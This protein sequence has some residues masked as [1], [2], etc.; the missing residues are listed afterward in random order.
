M[1]S[2]LCKPAIHILRRI[3]SISGWF[4]P[5]VAKAEDAPDPRRPR[6]KLQYFT[7]SPWQRRGWGILGF[8]SG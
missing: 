3:R 7:A 1:N 6:A 2:R 4:Y 8:P 5:A